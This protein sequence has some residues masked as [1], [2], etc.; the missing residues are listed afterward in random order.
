MTSSLLNDLEE[1]GGIVSHGLLI[2]LVAPICGGY[3]G[4]G[5]PP[6]KKIQIIFNQK[7]SN[8]H[9]LKVRNNII[10]RGKFGSV[11]FS[12]NFA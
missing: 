9:I 2:S 5:P 3:R 10:S 4:L 1:V 7:L 11:E 8:N 6:R 12:I